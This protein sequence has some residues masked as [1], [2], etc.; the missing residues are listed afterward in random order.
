[1]TPSEEG[2]LG[3]KNSMGAHFWVL[4]PPERCQVEKNSRIKGCLGSAYLGMG[5]LLGGKKRVLVSVGH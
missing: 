1:M 3:E 4:L 2:H 5:N